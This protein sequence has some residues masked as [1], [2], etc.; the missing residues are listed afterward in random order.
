MMRTNV[1]SRCDKCALFVLCVLCLFRVIPS[2]VSFRARAHTHTHMCVMSFHSCVIVALRK[3]G[4]DA[5]QRAL[6][7]CVCVR[8]R[9]CV[10]VR[11]RACGFDC[12]NVYVKVW[13]CVRVCCV[14]VC[15]WVG[16]WVGVCVCVCVYVCVCL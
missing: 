8:A 9:A 16:G 10:C 2:S 7:V 5:Y 3:L 11:A 6:K 1:P 12:V 15:L 13:V 14:C 4:D